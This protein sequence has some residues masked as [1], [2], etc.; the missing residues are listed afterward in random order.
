MAV[1]GQIGRHKTFSD[2]RIFHKYIYIAL[3]TKGNLDYFATRSNEV[4]K[5]SHTPEDKIR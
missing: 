2:T 3:Y 4:Y 5:Y 1:F